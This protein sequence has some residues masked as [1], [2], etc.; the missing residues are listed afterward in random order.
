MSHDTGLQFDLHEEIEFS[1]T[2]STPC[3]TADIRH[4]CGNFFNVN[5]NEK[6]RKRGMAERA[7][8]TLSVAI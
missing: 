5:G 2:S 4:R 7:K 3:R 1:M 6:K 8:H